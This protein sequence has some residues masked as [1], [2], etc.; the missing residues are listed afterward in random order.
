M[1]YRIQNNDMHSIHITIMITFFD[2]NAII[3]DYYHYSCNRNRNHYQY[4]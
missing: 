4:I 1:M 2:V 3:L